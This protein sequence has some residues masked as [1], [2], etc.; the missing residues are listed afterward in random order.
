MQP[1]MSK[2]LQDIVAR[3]KAGEC[4]AIPSV[5]SAHPEVLMASLQLAASLNR[6][7]VIEATSNQVNQLG[8]YTGMDA[9][10][11]VAFIEDLITKT[12]KLLSM[13]SSSIALISFSGNI[14]I[15]LERCF[16]M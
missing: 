16:T 4:V 5:C 7:L 11:F 10:T 1:I 3:N 2:M 9:Q 8:G 12:T 13:G 14:C 15:E 6:P